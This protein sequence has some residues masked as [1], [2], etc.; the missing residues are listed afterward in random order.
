MVWYGLVWYGMVWYDIVRYGMVW[1]GTVHHLVLTTSKRFDKLSPSFHNKKIR[2]TTTNN[3]LTIDNS[4]K[5]IP[6]LSYILQK[7][8]KR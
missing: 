2:V 3:V 7:V 8:D 4:L 6:N 5:F 1:Y